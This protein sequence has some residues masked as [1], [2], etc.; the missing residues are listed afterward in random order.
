MEIKTNELKPNAFWNI[1][2]FTFFFKVIA[3]TVISHY[4]KINEKFDVEV[5]GHIPVG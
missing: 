5:V 4:T 1:W 2:D 3:G